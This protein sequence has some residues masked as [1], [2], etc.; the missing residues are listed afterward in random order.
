MVKALLLA[1]VIGAAV[2][3]V[4]DLMVLEPMRHR[5]HVAG[6]LQFLGDAAD[7][8]DGDQG[9]VPTFFAADIN[10]REGLPR[11]WFQ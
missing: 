11:P 1:A 9:G 8:L 4:V 3:L 5:R 2:A 7:E 10:G 6:F